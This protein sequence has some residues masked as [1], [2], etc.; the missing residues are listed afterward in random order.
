M[1]DV[2]IV[3]DN[4]IVRAALRGFLDA[5]DEARVVAECGDGR[6][7]LATARRLRPAVTLLDYRMPIADGLSVVAELVAYSTVLVL[8]SDATHELIAAML[9]RGARGYLVHGEFDPPELLRA[10]L[11]VAAGQSWLSPVAASVAVAAVRQEGARERARQDR[12]ERERALRQRFGLTRR[13]EDVL[14]LLCAGLSNAAIARRL[15]LT[16]KTVKNHL[17]HIFAKLQVGN[18]TEAA[19]RWSGR[20]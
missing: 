9:R 10:V 4:P 15:S 5:S 20:Q 8:T 16:E 3:D 6:E 19:M 2:M 18:R 1:I 14:N 13:E 11:A 7:A 17:N 12:A